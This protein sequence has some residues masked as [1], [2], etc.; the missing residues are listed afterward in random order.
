LITHND[1]PQSVGFLWMGDQFVVETS[2][3]QHN[4]QITMDQVGFEPTI[5]VGERL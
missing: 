1:T 4:R 5:A 3:W 2:T